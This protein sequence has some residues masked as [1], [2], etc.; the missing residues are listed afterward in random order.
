[1]TQ[2]FFTDNQTKQK[3]Y[4]RYFNAI[5][6]SDF[7]QGRKLKHL[8]VKEALDDAQTDSLAS[9]YA[10]AMNKSR[11][12]E[13][14]RV[15]K[16]DKN[17]PHVVKNGGDTPKILKFNSRATKQSPTKTGS[18]PRKK[19]KHNPEITDTQMKSPIFP[20]ESYTTPPRRNPAPKNFESKMSDMP[21]LDLPKKNLDAIQRKLE[22][23]GLIPDIT[24]EVI[25]M[26]NDLSESRREHVK[27]LRG[28]SSKE[29]NAAEALNRQKTAGRAL[30]FM[31]RANFKGFTGKDKDIILGE[32]VGRAF[33]TAQE[34]STSSAD[35][36]D[37]LRNNTNEM[38]YDVD[39]HVESKKHKE[40]SEFEPFRFPFLF[41]TDDN[42]KVNK[43]KLNKKLDDYRVEMRE[44]IDETAS[45]V[46]DKI[47]TNLN[48]TKGKKQNKKLSKKIEASS[49]RENIISRITKYVKSSLSFLNQSEMQLV[50]EKM[51]TSIESEIPSLLEK[52]KRES[53]PPNKSPTDKRPMKRADIAP[54][55]LSQ[56]LDDVSDEDEEEKKELTKEKEQQQYFKKRKVEYNII[57]NQARR[58]KILHENLKTQF[59]KE[60]NEMIAKRDG[61]KVK[62]GNRYKYEHFNKEFPPDR[63]KNLSNDEYKKDVRGLLDGLYLIRNS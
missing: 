7:V 60:I 32:M 29:R 39:E 19:F 4:D 62:N 48:K 3:A 36:M 8:I 63:V 13:Y 61:K 12:Y 28:M 10:S 43:K 16:T 54:R 44:E 45:E 35:A 42:V 51:A 2:G 14:H 56:I 57:I 55:N 17:A 37:N 24:A 26:A 30:R 21:P 40:R 47:I 1:M 46:V 41:D 52:R 53:T 15:M 22:Q 18:P 31:K 5:A 34:E 50:A 27:A 33:A 20:S 9:M 59:G 11:D 58:S 23:K 6:T 49:T 25:G 38:K